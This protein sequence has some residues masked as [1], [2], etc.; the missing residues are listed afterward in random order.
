MYDIYLHGAQIVFNTITLGN[1]FMGSAKMLS[2][3]NDNY[4]SSST[5]G[6]STLGL[7]LGAA[8]GIPKG[9][10]MGTTWPISL[11]IAAYDHLKND[12][13]QN[14]HASH[15][16][17]PYHVMRWF[18]PN[19]SDDLLYGMYPKLEEG[20]FGQTRFDPFFEHSITEN[21][22]YKTFGIIYPTPPP[23]PPK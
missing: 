20:P 1:M 13:Y 11:P 4:K 23:I 6:K 15:T 10:L 5:L 3:D 7:G 2:N 22:L 8:Y 17:R 16:F 21:P 9:I 19:S 18:I 14:S 12:T